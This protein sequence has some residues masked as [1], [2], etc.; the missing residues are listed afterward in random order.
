MKGS[1]KKK[2]KASLKACYP[3]LTDTD[4][5]TLLPNKEELIV[6]KIFTF[7]EESVLLY[8]LA[9]HMVFFQVEKAGLMFWPTV[10]TLWRHP[11]LLPTLTTWPPV[12]ERLTRGADL[13]LPGVIVDE[14]RGLKAY[15]EGKLEKGDLVAVNLQSNKAPV[16]VGT[17]WLS[18]EDM[19]MAARKGK[20]VSVVHFYGDQ[21]WA[22]GTREQM[23]DLGPPSLNIVL[24]EYEGE[25]D[26]PDDEED[27]EVEEIVDKVESDLAITEESSN[28]AETAGDVNEES[29]GD[30]EDKR[31]PQE[32]MDE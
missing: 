2:L 31:S 10:Y 13:M 27:K 1:D 30:C 28:N 20:C 26:T 14:E 15:C 8:S 17:A 32:I 7:S 25:P 11:S 18:S 4:L 16:A 19:Y 12:L 5:A 22:A 23:P 21:L 24:G 6:S 9:K 3:A 29:D